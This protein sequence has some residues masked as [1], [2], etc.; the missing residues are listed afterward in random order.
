MPLTRI[1]D[2][3]CAA[4]YSCAGCWNP[5]VPFHLMALSRNSRS[6]RASVQTAQ[7]TRC[8]C[9]GKG[10]SLGSLII[11]Y[12]R[13]HH[14]QDSS[15]STKAMKTKA[16]KSMDHWG[17]SAEPLWRCSGDSLSPLFI[18]W[19]L[20]RSIGGWLASVNYV[21]EE[22]VNSL[23]TE[24]QNNIE[25]QGPKAQWCLWPGSE[26]QN[27]LIHTFHFPIWQRVLTEIFAVWAHTQPL[28]KIL[29]RF[30][31]EIPTYAPQII[32]I[33]FTIHRL[34]SSNLQTRTKLLL[35]SKKNVS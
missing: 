14:L 10:A 8:G 24:T 7:S 22:A 31:A 30:W 11:G 5:A 16:Y 12:L 2:Q 35:K 21:S 1:M 33:S 9:R 19:C 17:C 4:I 25:H 34:V 26:N 32:S 23:Y 3:F 20:K 18:F 28:Q 15:I 29:S 13:V 6:T 27:A